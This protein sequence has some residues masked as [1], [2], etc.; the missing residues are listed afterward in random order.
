MYTWRKMSES[1]KKTI[2]CT[3]KRQGNPWHQPPHF[4]EGNET[5]F[6]LTAACYEHKSIIGQS[7]E[8]LSHCEDEL[9][10]T[11]RQFSYEIHAWCILPNHYHILVNTDKI[12]ELL[13]ELGRWHGRSSRTWNLADA[14][15][16]R[17]VWFRIVERTM[18]SERHFWATINY[19][20]NNPI[21]HGY[22]NKWQ[23]WPFSSA[24]QFI[25]TFGRDYTEKLWNAYPIDRYGDT[26]DK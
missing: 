2:L 4:L 11:C 14:T 23:E 6:L 15:L 1:E 16:G 8:R 7:L 5:R 18:R 21:K 22:V 25:D 3:R 10:K 19:I 24:P 26:W 13:H 20:H 12:A 9:L 17:K